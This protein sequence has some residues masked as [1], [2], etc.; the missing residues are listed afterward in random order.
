MRAD[1]FWR[2]VTLGALAY[3]LGTLI[4]AAIFRRSAIYPR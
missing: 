3:P 2:G 4:G 1:T